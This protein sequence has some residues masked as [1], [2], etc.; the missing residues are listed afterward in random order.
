MPMGLALRKENL[1]APDR[2]G[3]A[4]NQEGISQWAAVRPVLSEVRTGFPCPEDILLYYNSS[5]HGRNTLAMWCFYLLTIFMCFQWAAIRGE[6]SPG[7]AW[8]LDP[9]WARPRA[10]PPL[11]LHLLPK[12]KVPLSSDCIEMEIAGH[13][14]RLIR[15]FHFLI[16]LL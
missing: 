9:G 10:T 16:N 8:A 15:V 12:S 4:Y 6:L 14:D 1:A 7:Q 5:A 11:Y 2:G 13:R 3:S